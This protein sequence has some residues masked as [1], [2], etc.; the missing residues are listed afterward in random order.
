MRYK[1][2]IFNKMILKDGFIIF[3]FNNIG[4]LCLSNGS[5]WIDQLPCTGRTTPEPCFCTKPSASKNLNSAAVNATRI[6]NKLQ[7]PKFLYHIYF[8]R[9]VSAMFR[10]NGSRSVRAR[11]VEE[12]AMMKPR[13]KLSKYTVCCVVYNYELNACLE[14]GDCKQ[15]Q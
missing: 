13:L 12:S 14:L 5:G 15:R 10:S 4:S 6:S 11:C 9:C 2:E 8:T 1:H 3:P 7:K